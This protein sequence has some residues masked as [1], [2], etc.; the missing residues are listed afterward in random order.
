MLRE[1]SS[2]TV[3][4]LFWS[5]VMSHIVP[6]FNVHANTGCRRSGLERLCACI[7]LAVS[8]EPLCNARRLWHGTNEDATAAAALQTPDAQNPGLDWAASTVI[9]WRS[10]MMQSVR[11]VFYDCAHVEV[12]LFALIG[13]DTDTTACHRHGRRQRV[14][15]AAFP[16]TAR[17]R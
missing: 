10:T 12:W 1:L 7:L 2:A 16:A 11:I 5:H 17:C 6:H 9:H 14:A 3:A 8:R 15:G 13:E 4:I